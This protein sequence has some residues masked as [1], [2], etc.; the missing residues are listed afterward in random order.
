MFS[1]D[2][3]GGFE[4]DPVGTDRRNKEREEIQALAKTDIKVYVQ[5]LKAWGIGREKQFAVEGC[6]KAR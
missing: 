2:C 6:R 1:P 4:P 5:V 3:E